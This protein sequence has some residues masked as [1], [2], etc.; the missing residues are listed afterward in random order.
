[1]SNL[2][3]VKSP[4]KSCPTCNRTFEDTF[5]FCLADGS[6]LNAPFD[7]QATQKI[8]EPRQTEPP[9]T[10]VLKLGETKE[11]IPPTVASPQSKQKSDDLVSTIAA[12]A[13]ASESQ[14][15]KSSPAQTDRK[16]G[17]WPVII[18]SVG[19]LLILGLIIF[20]TSNRSSGTNEDA[21]NTNAVGANAANTA[22]VVAVSN[23][24][25]ERNAVTPDPSPSLT[26]VKNLEG[27]TWQLIG[28]DGFEYE[29]FLEFKPN[30]VVAVKDYSNL[31]DGTWTMNGNK[32]TINIHE[33]AVVRGYVMS[34]TIEGQEMS[35]TQTFSKDSKTYD[36]TLR[37]IK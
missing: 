2:P 23:S 30:G 37:R 20:M 32:V 13:L 1:M 7:P 8:P 6:L 19:P 10:E 35:G 33:D 26:P 5:T 14:Q 3:Q 21:A 9:P 27:T 25:Q 15:T 36:F 11:E 29:N 24:N 31:R 28:K 22:T 4:M 34:G 18:F 16:S 12:P 17:L